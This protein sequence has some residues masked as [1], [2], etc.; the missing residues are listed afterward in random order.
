[1]ALQASNT[2]LSIEVIAA[3]LNVHI[4]KLLGFFVS[5][6]IFIVIFFMF[7]ASLL[8]DLKDVTNCADYYP[9]EQVEKQE[10]SEEYC[11][12]LGLLLV[13]ATTEKFP[14]V[15]SFG[16][17]VLRGTVIHRCKDSSVGVHE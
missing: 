4:F 14:W 15:F 16:T 1:M 5:T 12:G 10:R 13:E 3:V 17:V 9:P 8:P 2:E 7:F 11:Y 6:I